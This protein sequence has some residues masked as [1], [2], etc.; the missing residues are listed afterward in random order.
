M[1]EENKGDD[2]APA[3]NDD[4]VNQESKNPNADGDQGKNNSVKFETYDKVIKK[5]KNTESEKANLEE[6]LTRL[7]QLKLEAEGDKDQLIENLRS[8]VGEYKTKHKQAVG[9]FALS[10]GQMALVDEAVKMGCRSPEILTKVLQDELTSLDYGDDFR[11]DPEQ[12]RALVDRARKSN[13]ILFSKE[14]PKSPNHNNLNTGGKAAESPRKPLHELN[15]DEM[16]SMWDKFHT[17]QLR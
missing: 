8:Q 13:P 17:G 1:S 4:V 9:S 2:V 12:V 7:E 14:P 3:S 6:R 5:L 10:Q 16:N 11:P 15:D